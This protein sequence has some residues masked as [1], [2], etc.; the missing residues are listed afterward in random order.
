MRKS[1]CA[2]HK[3][4][5]TILIHTIETYE[6]LMTH[7]Q[8]SKFGL[9]ILGLRI[10]GDGVIAAW[11]PGHKRIEFFNYET[12]KPLSIDFDTLASKELDSILYSICALSSSAIDQIPDNSPIDKDKVY[13]VKERN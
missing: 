4:K 11:H 5:V 1:F 12:D 2:S 9:K 6:N 8:S 3:N 10:D 13:A 7:F